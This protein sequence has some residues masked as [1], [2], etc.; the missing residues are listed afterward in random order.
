MRPW[1]DA[2]AARLAA[3]TGGDASA[4]ALSDADVDAVLELAA[5][6]A[7]DSGDRT[8]APLVSYLVG[9]AQ[10][11]TGDATLAELARVAGGS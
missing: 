5:T 6:A 8:N 3:A 2:A 4:F 7:H 1:L 10:G 11:R 9:L